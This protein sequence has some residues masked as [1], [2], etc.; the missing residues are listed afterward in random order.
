MCD[1]Q[2]TRRS[3]C[4]NASCPPFIT[5]MLVFRRAFLGFS[6]EFDPSRFRSRNALRLPLMDKFP[7][8]LGDIGQQL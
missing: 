6:T 7:L 5:Q 4:G 1:T 3:A 2:L 8:G